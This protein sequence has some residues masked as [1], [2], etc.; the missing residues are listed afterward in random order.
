M[1]D[2]L[3]VFDR[4]FF[5]R[6]VEERDNDL[7]AIVAVDN[8]D[9]VRGASPS[10]QASPLRAYI[11]PT[12]PSGISNASPVGIIAVSEGFMRTEEPRQA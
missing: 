8:A 6:M 2:T 11:S 5:G 12:Y 10:L 1:R 3:T 7:S 4:P 9:F